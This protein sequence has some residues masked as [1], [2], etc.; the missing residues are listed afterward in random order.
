MNVY[1]FH[2][3]V[4]VERGPVN[5]L[6]IDFLKGDIFQVPKEYIDKFENRDYNAV[7]EFM[8]MVKTE[9]LVIETQEN[10]WIPVLNLEL[11]LD[12]ENK[13]EIDKPIKIVTL[14][15]EEGV[16]LH[17]V[18]RWFSTLNAKISRIFYYGQKE[19]GEI[20][21]GVPVFKKE[22]NFEACRLLVRVTG[23]FSKVKEMDYRLKINFNSC[24]C[25][26]IAIT[27]DGKFRPC[28]YST[29]VLGDLK[30]E[31]KKK[32]L[33]QYRGYWKITKRQVAVCKD[34]ELKYI[35]FDCRE[36]SF[37]ETGDLYGFNPY[38]RYDP[39]KGDWK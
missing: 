38:C 29:M 35:C 37:R 10:R 16:D 23:D 19:P 6:V 20:F 33:D 24:W 22:K 8:E 30:E 3:F 26:K 11:D 13:K 21:P 39:Y 25:G 2:Q 27:A 17:E 1:K 18:S 36:I 9:Q 31:D 7:P 28:I 32:I 15:I 34:C 5:A 12:K 4:R 14:E